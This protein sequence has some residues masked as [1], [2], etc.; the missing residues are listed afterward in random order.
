LDFLLVARLGGPTP[1]ASSKAPL[2]GAIAATMVI[3]AA[4]EILPIL[5][6]ALLAGAALLATRVL[7]FGEARNAI[8]LDVVLLIAAAFGV[9]AAIESSGLAGQLANGL[10]SGLD[11]LGDVGIIFGIVLSTTLLTELITNN[12]AAVV[13]FPIALSVAAETGLDE[14]AIAIAVA[15][16]ASSSFLTPMGY[17]TNTMVYGPGGYRFTDYLRLGIPLNLVVITSIT[18]MTLALS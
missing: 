2:V 14:R 17:Q 18:A 16:T 1:S 5:Q 15:I 12:A 13:I 9:G 7:S 8:D 3:L 6:G 4:L 10:V 11:G